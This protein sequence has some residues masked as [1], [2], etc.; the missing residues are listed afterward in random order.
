MER[1]GFAGP[2]CFLT[3]HAGLAV[4][5]CARVN[6]ARLGQPVPPG[7]C[8]LLPIDGNGAIQGYGAIEPAI[9]ADAEPGADPRAAGD[10]G[11]APGL[12]AG[13]GAEAAGQAA[14]DAAI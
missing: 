5:A 9:A 14:D 12:P 8:R 4:R 7:R 11:R 3:L 13:R 10:R 2:F 1:P 6:I